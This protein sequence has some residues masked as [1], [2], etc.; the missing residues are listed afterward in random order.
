[1]NILRADQQV[2]MMVHEFFDDDDT[3]AFESL[4]LWMIF[5]MLWFCVHFIALKMTY[6]TRCRNE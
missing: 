1:M 4:M 2:Y 3:T 6:F 5:Q